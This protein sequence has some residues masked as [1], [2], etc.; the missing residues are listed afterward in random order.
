[1]VLPAVRNALPLTA[2]GQAASPESLTVGEL[3]PRAPDVTLITDE[4]EAE[5]DEMGK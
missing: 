4:A 3:P 5:V 2:K 1:M